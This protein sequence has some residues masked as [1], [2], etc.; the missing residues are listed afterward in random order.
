MANF[1]HGVRVKDVDV[2]SRPFSTS[3]SSVIAIAGTAGKGAYNE[4]TLVT[5]LGDAV[6]KF[7][8]NLNDGFSLPYELAAIFGQTNAQVVVVNVADP[9]STTANGAENIVFNVNN[10]ASL[11]KRYVSSVV[12]GTTIKGKQTFDGND[13]I[14]LP[15][16]ITS[17]DSVKSEDGVT[18][19]ALT[20]DYTVASNVI[21]RVGGGSIAAGAKVLVE[22]TATLVENTDYTLDLELG[23]FTRL[24]AGKLIPEATLAI[25][26]YN[27]VST[28]VTDNDVIGGVSGGGVY[29]GVNA[30]LAAKDKVKVKPTIIAAPNFSYTK[31]TSG[32]NL[33]LAEL[34]T[35]AE[36]LAAQ[37]ISN[38]DNVTKEE[39]V[40]FK[41]LHQ[42]K[43]LFLIGSWEA[44]TYNGVKVNK[45]GT[46]KV[47]G[48]IAKNDEQNGVGTSPSNK[49]LN[50]VTEIVNP[51]SFSLTEVGF[52]TDY[53][54]E[55]GINLIVNEGGFRL[56]GNRTTSAD[57]K[58]Q[59]INVV[60]TA[61]FI[62][63]AIAANHLW[64][65]DRNITDDYINE[66]IKRINDFLADQI[67][68]RNLLKG[69]AWADEVLNTPT[70][71]Q[72]GKLFINF[73]YAVPS[74]AEDITF[75]AQLV[76]GYISEVEENN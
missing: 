56:W 41:E 35:V 25:T 46:A 62:K 59:F 27:S 67:G 51:F 17:V 58:W 50:G 37:V 71:K 49:K 4:P 57:T 26:S 28:T 52:D 63:A 70:N 3:S 68:A 33:V 9:T 20:T 38:T 53:L 1:H 14:T 22:Y 21:T 7:G 76:N 6:A 54:N 55:R 31:P 30:F 13:L 60:R 73:E 5:S 64:A 47:L 75:Q 44:V 69:R 23:K 10:E 29:T 19:Y 34:L 11:A 43:R 36:K 72:A 15:A 2:G 32:A 61:D 40:A 45:P 16:G 48:L 42:S 24:T 12:V 65:V 8:E 39:M 74:P 18:T 66:L